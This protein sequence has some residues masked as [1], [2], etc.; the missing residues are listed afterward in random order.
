MMIQI[1]KLLNNPQSSKV[2]SFLIGMGVVVLLFHKP[3]SFEKTLALSV[4]E[5]EGRVVPNGGKCY[6][7]VA[8][9]CPCE[10]S[11]AK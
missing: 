11:V 4:E 1:S 5:I 8:E 9:D 2:L 3:L 6:S 10:K 7:Y